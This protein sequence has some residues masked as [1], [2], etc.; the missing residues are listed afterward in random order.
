MMRS[1]CKYL[2]ILLLIC[3]LLKSSTACAQATSKQ[4]GSKGSASGADK[5]SGGPGFSIESEMLTYTA[6]ERNSEAVAKDVAP[7]VSGNNQGVVIVPSTSKVLADFELWRADMA[8]MYSFIEREADLEKQSASGLISSA[9]PSEALS[10]AHSLLATSESASPV[11]GTVKDQAFVDSVARQLRLLGIP[12][13][14]PDT[15]MPYS[16]AAGSDQHFLFLRMLERVDAI[17]YKL[18]GADQSHWSSTRIADARLLL[19]D[20]EVFTAAMFGGEVSPDPRSNES[21]ESNDSSETGKPKQGKTV[22]LVPFS[23]SHLASLLSADLLAQELDIDLKGADLLPRGLWQHVL[24]LKALESGGSIIRR[25]NFLRTNI[26]YSGGAVG[27]Y[28]LFNLKG[29]LEC[30]GNVYA[31]EGPLQAKEFQR[32]PRETAFGATLQGGCKV[33]Q[34]GSPIS[35]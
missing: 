1:G 19:A 22:P 20:I 23:S 5:E 2:L 26:R 27:T 7:L 28:A 35:K 16:L 32:R 4:D 24:W 10:I 29:E 3:G 31:Y 21:K 33:L 30:S 6:L 34:S 14:I 8:A 17:R 25:D 13:L 18:L 12:V 15:H 9:T 11:Q